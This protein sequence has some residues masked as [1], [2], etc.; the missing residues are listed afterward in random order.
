MSAERPLA[1]RTAIVTGGTRGIGRGIALALADAG[2]DVAVVS[3]TGAGADAVIEELSARGVRATARTFD[4]GDTQAIPAVFEDIAS[5]MGRLDVLVNNAGVQITGPAEQ[6]TEEDWDRTC[7][8][9]LKA[10]FF[11]AQALA[12]H[13]LAR[14]RRGKVVNITSNAAVVGFPD[15]SAYSASKGGL[16][17]L[18]RA[19]A[20]EWAQHGINVNAV[21]TVLVI[22]EMT[23][24]L[25]DDDAF[26]TRYLA[27]IPSGR[28]STV[29]DVGAAVVYLSSPAADQI[30]GHQL[31]VD[32]G[33]TAI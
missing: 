30:H 15:F 20:S 7:A 9:N 4:L 29:E 19:L 2:A 21:A 24:H 8:I 12:N 18:T 13:C 22:T 5:E 33:Y 31:M 11:C 3:Q 26:K 16:L 10:P 27:G 17:Q 1:G 32:G 14:G 25:L 6:V 23:R 28:F